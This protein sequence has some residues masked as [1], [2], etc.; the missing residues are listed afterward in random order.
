MKT[1]AFRWALVSL[2]V[3]FLAARQPADSRLWDVVAEYDVHHGVM[4]AGFLNEEYGIT[5]GPGNMNHT[6]DGGQSWSEDINVSDCRYGMEILDEQHAWTC[7]GMTH[8]RRS[9]DGGNIWQEAARFGLS[10]D[11][12]CRLM[13]F[14]DLQHGWLASAH[15]MGVTT[16]G[17]ASWKIMD[18]P[19]D[20]ESMHI[21][22]IGLY[23]PQHGYMMKTSGALYHTANDGAHWTP[24]PNPKPEGWEFPLSVYAVVTMRFSDAAHGIL[25]MHLRKGDEEKV[26]AYHTADGGQNWRSEP[27]PVKPGPLYISQDGRLLTVITGPNI[28]TVLRYNGK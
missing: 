24:V 18:E 2:N 25:V 26:I 3:V 16:D 20:T 13:S 14:V 5:G 21:V 17:A 9:N 6:T 11:G 27:V 10:R 1:S 23:A 12:P 4:T 8:V 19:K 15:H 28:M 7:G 22:G